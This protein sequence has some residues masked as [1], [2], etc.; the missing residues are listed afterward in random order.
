MK[1]RNYCGYEKTVF[2]CDIAF[3]GTYTA[4]SIL[5]IQVF[6]VSVFFPRNGS[7]MSFH[8]TADKAFKQDDIVLKQTTE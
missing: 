3:L 7:N 5:V 1:Y 8:V 4:P 6:W 2:P